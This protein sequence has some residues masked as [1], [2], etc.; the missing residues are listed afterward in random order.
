MPTNAFPSTITQVD[1]AARFPLG[2]EVTVPAKGAGTGLDQGE[3]TWIYVYNDSGSPLAVA[4]VQTR[5]AA[6]AAYHV[7]E[8]G[9]INPCQAVGVS[10]HAIANGSYGFILRRGVGTVDAAG[11]VTADKGLI[12][13]ASGEVTHEAAVTGS[14]MG[15]SLAGRSGAG[16]FT[17]Y[18]DCRG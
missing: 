17:A 6:T 8:A 10:Q 4:K 5:K 9:A 12:L 7:A 2:Y 3:E 15:N 13:I 16:T 11:T 14:A 18:V 1:T